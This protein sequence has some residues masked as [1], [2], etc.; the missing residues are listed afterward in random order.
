MPC[1][2]I[3]KEKKICVVWN[4]LYLVKIFRPFDFFLQ[5]NCSLDPTT[6]YEFHIKEFFNQSDGF[7]NKQNNQKKLASSAQ[8]FRKKGPKK[9]K[10]MQIETYLSKALYFSWQA[11]PPSFNWFR[12]FE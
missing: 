9:A 10:K 2:I 6:S 11:L 3:Q 8:R 4:V 1:Y 12:Y 7:E 5:I